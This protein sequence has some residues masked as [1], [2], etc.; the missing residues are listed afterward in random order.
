MSQLSSFVSCPNVQE[1]LALAWGYDNLKLQN[2]NIMRFLLSDVNRN[3][4]IQNQINFRAGGIKAV[5]VVYGQRFL[6]SAVSSTGRVSCT[7]FSVNGE[8]S[9][10][11]E[12]DPTA[13]A[14]MGVKLKLADLQ[15]RC[16]AD[17]TYLGR[18]VLSLMNV[19]IEKMETDAA[20]ALIANS[21][22][23]ASDVLNGNPAGTTAVKTVKT[24]S[25]GGVILTDAIEDVSFENMANEFNA[26]PFVF[27]GALWEKYARALN[28]ACCGDLGI[29]AGVYKEASGVTIVYA[30]KVQ[31]NASEVDYGYSVIPGTVQV[32]FFNEFFGGGENIWVMDDDSKK[33]GI[34]QHPEF[35]NLTFDYQATYT[36]DDANNKVWEISVGLAYDFIFLPADMYAAGDILDGVNGVLAFDID[37]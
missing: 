7:G 33:Q 26:K 23:F 15:T 12:I 29:D 6:E 1:S 5:E 28:A 13:G 36:C 4:F 25:S 8:T 9:K 30:P 16:E 21:G 22:N 20:L 19:L 35:P 11:Y 37:N 32:I 14:S 17:A 3:D 24:K 27:G 31:L 34:I 18:Q 2:V 10:V